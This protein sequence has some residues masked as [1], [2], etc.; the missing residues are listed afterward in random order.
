MHSGGTVHRAKHIRKILLRSQCM[1][2]PTAVAVR[3]RLQPWRG[4]VAEKAL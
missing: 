4:T 3:V 1:P 2:R